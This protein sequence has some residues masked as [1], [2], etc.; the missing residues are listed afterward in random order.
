MFNKVLVANRGE[1]AC[2]IIRTLD[3]MGIA[4]VAVY[5]EADR[6]APHVRMAGEAVLLG[7]PP[8]AESYLQAERILEAALSTGSEAIHPGYGF[9]SENAEFAEA[10]INAGVAF[11]GPTGEQMRRFGLKHE[12]RALAAA[13]KIP[14]LSG[15][16][17]LADRE[18]A[19]Q[20]A[21]I[22]GYPVMLKSTAGGGGIGMQICRSAEELSTAFESV[23]RLSRNFFKQE[24]IFLEKYVERARHVEVQ[25]FGDGQGT[26]IALGERDCSLQRRNQKVIEETPAPGLSEATRQAL[27]ASAVRLGEVV[28]YQSAG[29]V[30][31]ILDAS[32][33]QFYFLEV[34]T[35]LQVEHGVTELVSGIDLVEWMVRLA[36]GENPIA[37]YVH[38]PRGHAVEVRLYAEDPGKNFQPGAG[39][40]SEVR[41][42]DDVRLD[43]WVERGTEVTP[44]YDPLLAKLVVHGENRQAAIEHLI[45]ALAASE[46]AGIETNLDYLAQVAASSTFQSG[47]VST[48]FLA[49][50]VYTPRT[51]DVLTPGTQSTV[52]DYPGR[53][54][55]WNVG[56][57]PS[58]PMDALAFRL[59]N[60]LLGNR[61]TAA[62]LE[63]TL[64][65]PTL[66]FNAATVICLTGAHMQA[67]L[68]GEPV[69]YWQPVPISAGSTLRLGNI[70]GGGQRAYLAVRHGLDVPDYLGSKSTF[71]LGRFGG[72]AGRT[73]RT[74]DVL[75]LVRPVSVGEAVPRRAL[76]ETLTPHYGDTWELGVLYGPHGAPDFFTETDIEAFFATGWKVHH[77]S[78]R[79]GVRLI[80]PKPEWAREDGGEAGLH[81]SNIHDNAYAIGTVDFTGDM[82]VIL[83]PDGPSLGGFVCPATVVGAELWKIGQ[84]KPGDTVHF[85]RLALEAALEMERRQEAEIDTLEYSKL[86]ALDREDRA[87]PTDISTFLAIRS[88]RDDPLDAIESDLMAEGLVSNE[89]DE[90]STEVYPVANRD[91]LHQIPESSDQVAVVYRLCGDHYLL[92]EYGPPVL[93]LNLRFRVH[94][95]MT[96]LQTHSLPGMLEF[97]PGIRSLQIHFDS[98][99][100]VRRLMNRLLD[101]ERA[102]PSIDEIVVP[103]RV[104]YLPLSWEDPSTLLAIEKYTQGVNP[105]APWCPSNT[106]FIRRINGLESVEQ[107]REIVFS[108]SY[109]VLGL[110]DVYLGAPVATPLDPRHRL[111][112]TK[113]N[114]ARTWTPENAVGIGGAYLCIYGMEGPGGYQFVGRTLQVWNR[115]RST[116]DFEPGRPWLLRFFDQIR[117]YPVSAVELLQM[118]DQFEQGLLPLRIE[119]ETFSLGEYN[120]FLRSIA[121][122]AA[123]F[124][125]RQQAAFEAERERWAASKA[126]DLLDPQE[127]PMSEVSALPTGSR[128][129]VAPV[130]ANVWQI[131]VQVGARVSPGDP[132]VILES[133]KMEITVAASFAGTVTAI[134]VSRGQTVAAG[135]D[136]I[137]VQEDAP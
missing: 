77:N 19:Q 98:R 48:R 124:K 12:A 45:S 132:L 107:V 126:L 46:L 44:F 78:A 57:P 75:R 29:T 42:P 79:T 83:G 100:P 13:N 101:A 16:E 63:L 69:P 106:E 60:R 123:E 133:M 116:A 50:F 3:R 125:T 109:L 112:T 73:L 31:F 8:P 122:E 11:I 81:P 58:G 89:P 115:F 64:T 108:A 128:G 88:D 17:L 103:T 9:L 53:T 91:I 10:C 96:W 131:E 97:T 35:R 93:D 99:L 26:V 55:Y 113:Y 33:E 30:E 80:G 127:S 18:A 119:E 65:G 34:N 111:V 47:E 1:I 40:L 130:P 110:G 52:Q 14:L 27:Q 72:H 70:E 15:S 118:R 135:Q 2:R 61:T 114:P 25:I 5:S 43:G 66:R 92:I 76:A 20:Q 94:A 6:H 37:G 68:D 105:N 71:T 21:Q 117:F 102:L 49:D 90:P 62:G 120:A 129:E 51:I 38:R 95:L 24:G 74:G 28:Q 104:V 23:Q 54:G 86:A 82:P 32:S 84:L 56:V 22:V 121:P 85:R 67:S 134:L 136:L 41:F 59:A 137:A 7:P 87:D 36:A 39:I 4:S